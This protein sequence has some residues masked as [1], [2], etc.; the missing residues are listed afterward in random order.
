[1][2]AADRHEHPSRD[3]LPE[4]SLARGHELR[5]FGVLVLMAALGAIGA[6]VLVVSLA[7]AL[8]LDALAARDA[9]RLPPAAP[10]AAAPTPPQPSLE[11]DSGAL[12]GELR[13]AEDALLDGYGWIDREQG[14]VRIPIERAM[15]I[16][17]ERGR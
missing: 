7:M 14:R 9:D 4:D 8:L 17:A 2:S 16:I 13:T 3:Q 5:D 6:L 11:V 1:M 10:P 15:Q 12:L